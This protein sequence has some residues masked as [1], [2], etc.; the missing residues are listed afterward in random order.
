MAEA[1]PDNL[2][3]HHLE[4]PNMDMTDNNLFSSPF[5]TTVTEPGARATLPYLAQ[6]SVLDQSIV[7]AQY[8]LHGPG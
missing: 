3:D 1:Q 7:I 5:T 8:R 2:N 6:L 4:Q